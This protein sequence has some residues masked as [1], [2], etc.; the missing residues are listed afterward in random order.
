MFYLLRWITV[1][2]FFWDY[3]IIINKLRTLIFS[4]RGL[5][6]SVVKLEI[7][8]ME[9]LNSWACLRYEN[10][11]FVKSNASVSFNH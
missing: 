3:T 2:S 10:V 6:Y 4:T 8:D 1:L 7:V 9:K 5:K 11:A